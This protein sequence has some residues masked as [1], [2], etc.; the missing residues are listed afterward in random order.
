MRAVARVKEIWR[1]PVKSM[2]GEAISSCLV[3]KQGLSG[4]RLWAITDQDGDIKSA[5]QWPQ[6]LQM[7]AQYKDSA[8][9]TGQIYNTAVP[10][11]LVQIPGNSSV[12][13]RAPEA[14]Q[15]LSDFIGKPC[16][17]E[18]LRP[19]NDTAFYT[20]KKERDITS[21]SVELDQLEDEV[22]LDFSQTPEEM[23][24]LL[25]QYMT[26]PG[27][28]FDSFP[29]HLVSTN[30]LAYLESQAGVDANVRRF[31][32]NIL[33]EFF[34]QHDPIVEFS[35]IGKTVQ[36]GTATIAPQGQTIRCS[37]PSRPQP[38]VNVEAEP[39]MT[40]AMV[41]LMQRHVGVYSNI[42]TPGAVSVGDEVFISD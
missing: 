13:A 39:K 33:L 10:D 26:P 6:L 16:R 4:D 3:T 12:R 41:D 30:A 27:T 17:I 31:R 14:N 36:L 22:E 37:I 42:V 11:V 9:S 25:S 29:M 34:E 35:L 18:P 1:Y 40:R 5:R 38:L 24:E 15:I 23:F 28:Y 7:L 19:P 2:G 20:P 21:L 32:P 8:P